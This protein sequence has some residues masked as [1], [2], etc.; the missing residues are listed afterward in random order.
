MAHRNEDQS[1]SLEQGEENLTLVQGRYAVGRASSVELTDA[2]VAL[3]NARGE[4]IQAEYDERTAV[5]QI[6][7]AIGRAR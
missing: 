3:A 1:A 7:R 6:Q 5:A 4:R 2:Q